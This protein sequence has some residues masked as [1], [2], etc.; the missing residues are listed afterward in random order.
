MTSYQLRMKTLLYRTECKDAASQSQMKRCLFA[1]PG[2]G[3]VAGWMGQI[4]STLADTN[5][6]PCYNCW[7]YNQSNL[8]KLLPVVFRPPQERGQFVRNFTTLSEF[9]H[10]L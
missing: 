7:K 8:I 9:V 5:N 1:H 4:A 2:G 10:L 6:K 3:G